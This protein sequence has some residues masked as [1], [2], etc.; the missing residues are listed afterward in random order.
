MRLKTK[1]WAKVPLLTL[2]K[3]AYLA[4][5]KFSEEQGDQIADLISEVKKSANNLQ[6]RVDSGIKSTPLDSGVGVSD[7]R[8]TRVVVTEAHGKWGN[9]W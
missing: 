9:D 1:E 7:G 6:A 2:F 8:Q 4:K 3:N 5:D